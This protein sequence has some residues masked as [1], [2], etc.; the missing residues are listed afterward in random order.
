MDCTDMFITRH[1]LLWVTLLWLTT[2]KAVDKP[3]S[4]AGL[5]HTFKGQNLAKFYNLSGGWGAVIPNNCV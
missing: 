5:V 2:T 4:T 1:I 3:T